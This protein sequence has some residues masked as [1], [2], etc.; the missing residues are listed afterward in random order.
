MVFPKLL[1]HFINKGSQWSIRQRRK[2]KLLIKDTTQCFITVTK[3]TIAV[4]GIN[5]FISSVKIAI[6]HR[7]LCFDFNLQYSE[8]VQL[9]IFSYTFGSVP[10]PGIIQGWDARCLEYLWRI[11]TLWD[12]I[13]MDIVFHNNLDLIIIWG[14]MLHN[15]RKAQ[16]IEIIV[17]GLKSFF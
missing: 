7:N 17:L 11:M 15:T 4:D 6:Y 14:F 13:S 2:G 10:A 12:L 9:T 5:L 8:R 1:L 16:I 3:P